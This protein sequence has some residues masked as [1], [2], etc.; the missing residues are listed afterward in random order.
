MSIDQI[1]KVEARAILKYDLAKQIRAI[2]DEARIRY[3]V[4]A[5][6]EDNLDTEIAEL[7]FEQT[8]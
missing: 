8:P 2:L 7:V 1:Q 4:E 3:G 5:W 6:D